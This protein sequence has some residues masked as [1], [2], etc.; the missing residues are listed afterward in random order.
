MKGLT[1]DRLEKSYAV[2]ALLFSEDKPISEFIDREAFDTDGK[3]FLT[4]LYAIDLMSCIRYKYKA[5]S[6]GSKTKKSPGSS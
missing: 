3:V 1:H 4:F 2:K 6:V 5:R